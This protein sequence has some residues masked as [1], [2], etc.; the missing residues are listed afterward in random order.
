MLLDKKY[1]AIKK[2]VLSILLAG[3]YINFVIDSLFDINH[4][5]INNLSTLTKL[6]AY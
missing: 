5:Q 6:R 2:L 3:R 1:E 4:N